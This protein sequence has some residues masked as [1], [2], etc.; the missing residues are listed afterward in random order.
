M[1][2]IHD[3]LPIPHD[4]QTPNAYDVFGLQHGDQDMQRITDRVRLVIDRLKSVKEQTDPSLW[5][6]A[7]K[8]VDQARQILAD[9]KRKAAL[10]AKLQTA[11]TATSPMVATEHDDPLAGLLPSG[12]P[13]APVASAD[14]ESDDD[15]SAQA[16]LPPGMFGTPAATKVQQVTD[17]VP[18]IVQAPS[19]TTSRS[20]RKRS[21]ANHWAVALTTLALLG[22]VVSLGYFA[23]VWQGKIEISKAGD[24]IT[25]SAEP[26]AADS[27]SE[28]QTP[29][30]ESTIVDQQTD[31]DQVAVKTEP[32]ALAEGVETRTA[33][34]V[35]PQAEFKDIEP[36]PE[37]P[38][39]IGSF[40]TRS[41]A[42]ASRDCQG[43]ATDQRR[44]L[45]TNEECCRIFD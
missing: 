20:R 39:S 25:V 14:D 36:D 4:M 23:F 16:T 29:L 15:S 10:D 40:E 21:S 5:Q 26:P 19:E 27:T 8:L 7:A 2:S 17:T 28:N 45:G 6:Q 34:R 24:T 11:N 31:Q 12:N 37:P 30:P 9:P 33:D 3:L 13:L 38:R 18:T 44:E 22:L 1:P 42:T 32:T 43:E 41:A 35:V